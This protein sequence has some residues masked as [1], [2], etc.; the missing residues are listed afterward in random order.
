LKAAGAS[1]SGALRLRPG[2]LNL[3]LCEVNILLLQVLLPLRAA[4][5]AGLDRGLSCCWSAAG[6]GMPETTASCA[7]SPCCS[8]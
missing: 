7:T 2:M 3:R 1:P 6:L 5:Q 8:M 4:R